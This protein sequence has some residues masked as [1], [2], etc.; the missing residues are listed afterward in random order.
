MGANYEISVASLVQMIADILDVDV[1]ITLDPQRIR[2][3]NSE[4][5]RLW[6]DNT[7]AKQ[8]LNWR[9][10]LNGLEGLRNGLE[11]TIA[12]FLANQKHY[13]PEIYNL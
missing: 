1:K 2:P 4:V 3:A 7:L 10:A 9:P 6:S 12:W 8:L 13:K 11:Q 5:E